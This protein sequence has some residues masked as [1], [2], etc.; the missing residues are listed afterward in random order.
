MNLIT[1]SYCNV[2]INLTLYSAMS[3]HCVRGWKADHCTKSI[4]IRYYPMRWY[5]YITY[6]DNIRENPHR[7]PDGFCFQ[8]SRIRTATDPEKSPKPNTRPQRIKKIHVHLIP[9]SSYFRSLRILA[10]SLAYHV[11]RFMTIRD[12]CP[13]DIYG[14]FI[15]ANVD[16]PWLMC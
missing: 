12:G 14:F 10:A 6:T 7:I 1:Q 15:Y 5:A 11:H 4:Q 8:I 9:H 16:T 3:P 2:A 13:Q